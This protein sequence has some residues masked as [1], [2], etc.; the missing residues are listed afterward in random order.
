MLSPPFNSDDYFVTVDEVFIYKLRNRHVLTSRLDKGTGDLFDFVHK[1]KITGK[2]MKPIM[3]RIA[4]GV[5]KMHYLN[6]IHNDLKIENIIMYPGDIP[7]I[8]DFGLSTSNICHSK[9]LIRAGTLGIGS[10]ETDASEVYKAS[11]VWALGV[12]FLYVYYK[13]DVIGD[14]RKQAHRENKNLPSE[15]HKCCSSLYEGCVKCD[16]IMN[17]VYKLLMNTSNKDSLINRTKDKDPQFADL[18][19]DIRSFTNKKNNCRTNCIHPFFTDISNN[20]RLKPIPTADCLYRLKH[21]AYYPEV[22]NV[23]SSNHKFNTF[24]D[25]RKTLNDVNLISEYASY[26]RRDSDKFTGIYELF[27]YYCDMY[28]F[29]MKGNVKRNFRCCNAISKFGISTSYNR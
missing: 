2:N 5:E 20:L 21:L 13:R 17:E 28:I 19:K 8:A 14:L 29:L 9:K 15:G 7:K 3:F 27:N 1:G 11:D 25:K 18:F 26:D 24:S 16:T 23:D 12:I 6:I 10:P 4:K 22:I